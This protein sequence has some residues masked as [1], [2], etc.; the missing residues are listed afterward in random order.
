MNRNKIG[1]TESNDSLMCEVTN[2]H[3]DEPFENDQEQRDAL[4]AT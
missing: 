3:V 1:P 2:Q 4:W